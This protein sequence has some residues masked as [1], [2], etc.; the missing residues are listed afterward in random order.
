HLAA[1]SHVDRSISGPAVFVSTNVVGTCTLLEATR[2]VWLEQRKLDPAT[3][4]FCH[5]STG[6][7][8]GSLAPEDP[9][10]T[11]TTPYDPRSPYSATKAGSDHLV[12]AYHH[13]Y[14]LPVVMTN[15]SNNYGPRQHDEKFIPTIIRSCLAG[16]GIPVYG[17]GSNIRDW[18]YVEDH[19]RA[20]DRVVRRGR[21]GESYNIGGNCELSNIALVRRIS[22]MLDVAVPTGAPHDRLIQ[23][24][25]D[26]PGHDWRYAMDI[27][28]IGAEL[29]WSP[30]ESLNSGLAKTIDWYLTRHAGDAGSLSVAV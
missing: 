2:R 25:T 7:V 1:E 29:G 19:C 6:E 17:T 26:R 4:R 16:S 22:A 30:A 20:I 14:G 18:L 11:E 28:K 8:F 10:F 23:F 13:T 27:A 9:A 3:C 5:V 24:V 12:R 15:C 21:L